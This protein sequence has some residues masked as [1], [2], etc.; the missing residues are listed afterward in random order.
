MGSCHAQNVTSS[1]SLALPSR[2]PP[3]LGLRPPVTPSPMPEVI[4]LLWLPSSSLSPP[5]PASSSSARTVKPSRHPEVYILSD[6]E[7]ERNNKPLVP[8]KCEPEVLDLMSDEEKPTPQS[9][10]H[11]RNHVDLT[12]SPPPSPTRDRP[13]RQLVV[14]PQLV[15]IKEGDRFPTLE[16]AIQAIIS[17]GEAAGFV[18][19]RGG[20]QTKSTLR[21]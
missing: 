21:K 15:P 18:M 12:M 4:D 14:G 16:A 5:S 17:Q 6:S 13:Q 20:A 3:L 2:Q 19:R 10:H 11:T 1:T 7:S 8:T 9:E